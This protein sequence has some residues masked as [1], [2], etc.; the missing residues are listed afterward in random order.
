MSSNKSYVDGI[1]DL[2]GFLKESE[3]ENEMDS[4]TDFIALVERI[5]R[6]RLHLLLQLLFFFSFS[7]I[8]CF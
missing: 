8:F 4:F 2:R 7:V 1:D 3:R 5:E 6:V